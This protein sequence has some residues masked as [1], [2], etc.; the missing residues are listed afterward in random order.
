MLSY[1]YEKHGLI[2]K[3]DRYLSDSDFDNMFIPTKLLPAS[4]NIGN[5]IPSINSIFQPYKFTGTVSG[6]LLNGQKSIYMRIEDGNFSNSH[7][8]PAIVCDYRFTK[9]QFYFS[10]NKLKKSFSEIR[11]K[12]LEKLEENF[13]DII[14]LNS[15]PESLYGIIVPT[16]TVII[17]GKIFIT[18]TYSSIID[19][20]NSVRKIYS[21]R[22]IYD[23]SFNNFVQDWIANHGLYLETMT[24]EDY[25]FMQLEYKLSRKKN[26][27][28]I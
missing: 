28:Q 7:K 12:V 22:G 3:S 23:F 13:D 15:I 5:Y 16:F 1:R 25:K 8:Y 4:F 2:I 21:Y 18:S 9:T 20:K 17:D 14:D 10:D 19:Y 24:K 6:K 27:I 26:V 11:Q